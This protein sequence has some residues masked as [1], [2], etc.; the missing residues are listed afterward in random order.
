MAERYEIFESYDGDHYRRFGADRR[1]RQGAA[2]VLGMV[3]LPLAVLTLLLTLG[4]LPVLVYF[5]P[6]RKSR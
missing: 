2:A 5:D 3:L 4:V 1:P 6:R